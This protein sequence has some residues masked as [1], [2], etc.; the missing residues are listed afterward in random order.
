MIKVILNGEIMSIYVQVYIL[1][2]K[3]LCE[4]F[5][6]RLVALDVSAS[7]LCNNEPHLI[8][9]KVTIKLISEMPP[10]ILWSVH[11]HAKKRELFSYILNLFF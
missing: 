3:P 9:C 11:G 5:H 6:P 4:N 1:N 2:F 7:C 8:D 10:V